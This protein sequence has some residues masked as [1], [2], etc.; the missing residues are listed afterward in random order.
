[1]LP[2]LFHYFSWTSYKKQLSQEQN[3]I[4]YA[5]IHPR[6][7]CSLMCG[8]CTPQSHVR[9]C[10]AIILICIWKSSKRYASLYS[11]IFRSIQSL[12]C[13]FCTN[14]SNKT[15]SRSE[16]K[17]NDFNAEIRLPYSNWFD[18]LSFFFSVL[19]GSLLQVK[20]NTC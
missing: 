14:K 19:I 1:M 18:H 10:E 7:A 13:I 20:F 8:D 9:V 3:V 16:Q 12:P 6:F 2:A 11:I 4:I 15:S 17:E 5:S